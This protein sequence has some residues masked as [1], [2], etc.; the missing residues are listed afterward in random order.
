M[1]SSLAAQSSPLIAR[2]SSAITIHA[3]QM[4]DGRGG[5]M[6]DV[7]IT[8]HAGRIE[9]TRIRRRNPR[10]LAQAISTRR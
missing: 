3:A 9:A 2:D 6:R 4:L 5:R 1:A 8:V 7:M 10:S